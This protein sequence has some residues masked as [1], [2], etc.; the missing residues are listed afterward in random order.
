MGFSKSVAFGLIGVAVCN[1][2]FCAQEYRP[3]VNSSS[4]QRVV[5]PLDHGPHAVTTPWLNRQKL[6]SPSQVD[7][8]YAPV[9]DAPRLPPD[10]IER[11][12]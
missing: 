2:A 6:I 9:T 11:R 3:A 4:Q 1:V 8:R 12:P 10:S 7:K 5:L